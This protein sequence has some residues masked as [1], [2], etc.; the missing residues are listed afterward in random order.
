MQ[1]GLHW[2]QK[3]YKQMGN[4]NAQVISMGRSLFSDYSVA[5]SH[6]VSIVLNPAIHLL[7][8]QHEWDLIYIQ[9]SNKIMLNM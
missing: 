4:S 6:Y 2:A 9:R 8:I 7:W 5:E 1:I 3:Y